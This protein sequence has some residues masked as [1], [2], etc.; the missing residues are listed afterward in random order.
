MIRPNQLRRQKLE[1]AIRSGFTTAYCALYEIYKDHLYEPDY[2]SFPE[3]AKAVLGYE[4]AQA[5]RLVHFAAFLAESRTGDLAHH[6][7][8]GAFRPLSRLKTPSDKKA[9]AEKIIELVRARAAI[10][11]QVTAQIAREIK[12]H[13]YGPKK[14]IDLD[15][16]E[17]NLVVAGF[18]DKLSIASINLKNSAAAG[19]ASASLTRLVDT[20]LQL[21]EVLKQ[22]FGVTDAAKAESLLAAYLR[23]VDSGNDGRFADMPTQS[24][25]PQKGVAALLPVSAE[26]DS[27]ESKCL[28]EEMDSSASEMGAEVVTS[29]PDGERKQAFPP[30][31]TPYEPDLQKGEKACLLSQDLARTGAKI[32]SHA[33][34]GIDHRIHVTLEV[35]PGTS[36]LN[37]HCPVPPGFSVT[38]ACPLLLEAILAEDRLP[39]L[40]EEI[41]FAVNYMTANGDLSRLKVFDEEFLARAKSWQMDHPVGIV[42]AA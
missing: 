41:A 27:E 4:K 13:S 7:T 32:V 34:R 28:I 1:L 5:Y 40:G 31:I 3:Y 14:L 9:A 19:D 35:T 42:T 33:Y 23:S 20:G 30:P 15:L 17:I 37:E 39:K 11:E 2:A 24:E 22:V 25:M 10:N 36:Q 21:K 29:G 8:E 6:L 38:K 18:A 16:Y 12:P 26:T